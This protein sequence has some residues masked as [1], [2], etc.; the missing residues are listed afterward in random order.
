MTGIR[1]RPLAEADT[2]SAADYYAREAG[3]DNALRFLDALDRAY[4]RL[5]R[6]PCIGAEV[7]PSRARLTGLRFWP[8]PGFERYLVFYLPSSDLVEVIRVLHTAR[9]LSELLGVGESGA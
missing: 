4:E 9:D 5:R 7:R 1:I 6:H 2:D 3:L 8:V